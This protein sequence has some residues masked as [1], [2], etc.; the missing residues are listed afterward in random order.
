M[1]GE[2]K[3]ERYALMGVKGES[4][5]QMEKGCMGETKDMEEN[6]N[7]KLGVK[8]KTPLRKFHKKTK[9]DDRTDEP[10]KK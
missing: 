9:T 4:S 1:E 5:G 6:E 3:W 2:G 10:K 7:R 8:N